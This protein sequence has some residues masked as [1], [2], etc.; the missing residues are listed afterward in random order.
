MHQLTSLRNTLV[1]IAMAVGA[2]ALTTGRT[3][4]TPSTGVTTEILSL[5]NFD[6]LDIHTR[7]VIDP[8]ATRPAPV[9]KSG[10]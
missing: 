4:A 8:A 6:E 1:V 7:T 2:V 5:C 9:L 10:D 3:L